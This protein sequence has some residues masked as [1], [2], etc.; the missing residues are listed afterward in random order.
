MIYLTQLIYIHEGQQDIFHQFEDV[1]L[2]LLDKYQGKLLLRIRPSQGQVIA[3]ELESPYEVHLV[4]FPSQAAFDGFKQDK[5]R[6]RFLHL[7]DAS[8][9]KVVLIQGMSL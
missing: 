3:G 2:P 9:R 4:S 6:E 1:A 7:K 5:E 8:V